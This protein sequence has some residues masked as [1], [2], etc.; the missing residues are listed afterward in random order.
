M[1]FSCSVV[2]TRSPLPGL[3]ADRTS[4]PCSDSAKVVVK[5]K[6][7]PSMCAGL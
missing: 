4:P 5:K 6:V 3:T 1:V 2:L 7:T